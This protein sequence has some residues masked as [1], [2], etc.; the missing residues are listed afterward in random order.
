MFFIPKHEVPFTTKKCIYGKIVCDIKPDKVETHRTR[1]K[2]GG[3][4]LEYSGVLST[5]TATVTTTKFLLNSIISTIIDKCL[6]ADI[7]HFYLK[8]YLHNTE[9]MKLHI[10]IIPE[11]I[12]KAYNLS[13]IQYNNCWV[14]MKIC[15]GM[16]GLKQSGT[17][18]NLELKRHMENFGYNPVYF[19]AGIWK[20]ETNEI[21]FTLSVNH[22]CVK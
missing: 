14:Y 19:T 12:I 4:L 18:T 1:L 17:I 9:H 10:S 21:I 5:L 2:V 8:N 7:K 3:N 11:K 6:T 13:N 22:L 15:K 16:Y 20:H